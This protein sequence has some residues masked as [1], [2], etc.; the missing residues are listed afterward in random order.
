MMTAVAAQDRP[1]PRCPGFLTW[2]ANPS[3]ADIAEL[4][5]MFAPQAI[6]GARYN[7]DEAMRAGT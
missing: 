3:A 7:A 4:D 1:S 5:A 6:S 2:Q